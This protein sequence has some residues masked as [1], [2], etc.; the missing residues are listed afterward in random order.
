MS[1]EAKAFVF[2]TGAIRHTI[3]DK[4]AQVSQRSMLFLINLC[5]SLSP[6]IQSPNLKGELNSYIE[7]IMTALSDK[8]GDNLVKVRT[9]AEDTVMAMAEHPSFGLNPCLNM[10][11]K[12]QVAQ[13]KDGGAVKKAMQSNKHIIGRY[14]MLLRLLSTFEF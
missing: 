13:S 3:G 1:D 8:L 12:S 4:M 11:I 2:G 7:P 5:K 10:L 14:Q 9:L 6:P